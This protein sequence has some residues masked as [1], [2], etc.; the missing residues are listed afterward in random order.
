M[1]T[2][3]QSIMFS[4]NET[5]N[6]RRSSYIGHVSNN[7]T[8]FWIFSIRSWLVGFVNMKLIDMKANCISH[9]RLMGLRGV[10][11]WREGGRKERSHLHKT[12]RH[13]IVSPGEWSSLKYNSHG[14]HPD[15]W[16]GGWGKQWDTRARQ[17]LLVPSLA[18]ELLP[19]VLLAESHQFEAFAFSFSTHNNT[20]LPEW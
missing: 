16:K 11:R 1:M 15:H 14:G 17:L 7:A 5:S 19:D 8:F 18:S 4:T 20:S 2:R 10:G 12:P 9:V 13:R 3:K 6:H